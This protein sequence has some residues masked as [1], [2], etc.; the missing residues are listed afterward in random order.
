MN[1]ALNALGQPSIK[2]NHTE[3]VVTVLNAEKVVVTNL[4]TV[5]LAGL[6]DKPIASENRGFAIYHQP[7]V[8]NNVGTG[9]GIVGGKGLPL[10]NKAC[11]NTPLVKLPVFIL[12]S[13]PHLLNL[14]VRLGFHW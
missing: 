10:F 13:R 12:T 4:A 11:V 9:S 3:E 14:D 8:L 2:P 6:I 7:K 1:L 5:L